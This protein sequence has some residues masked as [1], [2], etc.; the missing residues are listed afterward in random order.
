MLLERAGLIRADLK[1]EISKD[2]ST[3]I[4]LQWLTTPQ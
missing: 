2:G 1:G 3:R 4:Y